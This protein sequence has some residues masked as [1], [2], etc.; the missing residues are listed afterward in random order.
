MQYLLFEQIGYFRWRHD[1]TLIIQTSAYINTRFSW[2]RTP[3][4]SVFLDV[5]RS[6]FITK[7]CIIP[8]SIYYKN[9][10]SVL[11]DY[12]FTKQKLLSRTWISFILL[13]S[14]FSGSLSC[15]PKSTCSFQFC[16]KSWYKVVLFTGKVHFVISKCYYFCPFSELEFRK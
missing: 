3:T 15:L 8:C 2:I 11:Q 12:A 1:D 5:L 4:S 14:P 9:I 13:C 7:Y 16:Y 6:F 10:F